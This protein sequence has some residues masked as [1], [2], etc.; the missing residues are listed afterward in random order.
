MDLS[1]LN[2]N[3]LL[4]LRQQIDG[5]LKTLAPLLKD[6]RVHVP[7]SCLLPDTAPERRVSTVVRINPRPTD[8]MFNASIKPG[9][10]YGGASISFTEVRLVDPDRVR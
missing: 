3:Q 8:G 9:G 5:R 2:W 4:E 1:S 10:A 7:A 6:E